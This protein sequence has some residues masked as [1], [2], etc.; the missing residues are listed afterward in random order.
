MRQVVPRGTGFLSIWW[1]RDHG[2]ECLAGY[3]T[4]SK[5]GMLLIS[6]RL[7]ETALLLEI[8]MARVGPGG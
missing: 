2:L 7:G 1:S 6:D 5:A 8:P 3:P 4:P